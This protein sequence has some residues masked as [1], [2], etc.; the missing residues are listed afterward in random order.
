MK[1]VIALFIV[2][3]PLYATAADKAVGLGVLERGISLWHIRSEA[4]TMWGVE[5][6]RL[7]GVHERIEFEFDTHSQ[8]IE[9]S[10]WS[11]RVSLTRKGLTSVSKKVSWLDYQSVFL[12]GDDRRWGTRRELGIGDLS[13]GVGVGLGV[14]WYPIDRVGIAVR[15]GFEFDVGYQSQ[16]LRDADDPWDTED[17]EVRKLRVEMSSPRLLV[18]VGF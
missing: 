7:R 12:D 1:T 3:V 2:F 5:L 11:A 6:E 14:L 10:E 16:E 4:Q 17:N 8:Q 18:L 9:E 13:V 15:Q